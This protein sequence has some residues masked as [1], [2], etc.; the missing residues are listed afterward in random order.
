MKNKNQI[1]FFAI[2]AILLP[3][4]ATRATEIRQ[5][6]YEFQ[7]KITQKITCITFVITE[8]PRINRVQRKSYHF[9][10]I[11]FEL[12]STVLSPIAAETLLESMK[13]H[14]IAH[15]TPLVITGYSCELGSEQYNLMLS[16]QRAVAVVN[17]LESQGF[18]MTTLQAKGEAD[19][20]TTDQQELFKNRRVEITSQ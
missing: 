2:S 18:S 13:R 19:P 4:V 9:P 16:H 3:P 14:R 11:H 20:I 1:I 5:E 12:G 6:L 10:K 7:M 15:H 17:F 8:T